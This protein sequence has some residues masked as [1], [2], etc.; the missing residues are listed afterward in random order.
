ML[1]EAGGLDPDKVFSDPVVLR[2]V[3][4]VIAD[5]LVEEFD[6]IVNLLTVMA[7]TNK[8]TMSEVVEQVEDRLIALAESHGSSRIANLVLAALIAIKARKSAKAIIEAALEKKQATNVLS[9]N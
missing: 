7:F 1:A 3:S 9:I 6:P 5:F 2:L 4:L 8:Q